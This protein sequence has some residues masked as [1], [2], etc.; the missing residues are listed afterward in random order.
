MKWE[1]LTPLDFS[2]A[3]KQA[4]GVCLLPLGVIE[5]HPRLPL[6]SELFEPRAIALRAAQREPAIVFPWYYFGQI[7]E[8]KH[9][10]GTVA[11]RGDTVLRLL[12]NV[13]QEISRNGLK[14]ILIVNGHGVTDYL[15]F[16]IRSMLEERRDFTPYLFNWWEGLEK[17]LQFD[18]H[19]AMELA[20][21][22]ELVKLEQTPEE[23]YSPHLFQYDHLP[24]LSCPLPKY[25]GGDSLQDGDMERVNE[26]IQ[27]G[28]NLLEAAADHLAQHI[29]AVKNDQ[30]T[31][32]RH[33]KFFDNC[34][35]DG[36]F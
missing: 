12:T 29:R 15:T 7:N 27:E 5:P 31:A 26:G 9:V 35:H 13:C 3:V 23:T 22:R 19:V 1:E 25:G 2:E 18:L 28:K 16:F 36:A 8:T 33:K 11:L 32:S 30:E 20:I 21:H 14:K 17:A 6:G 10:P 4:Q 24:G 34:E